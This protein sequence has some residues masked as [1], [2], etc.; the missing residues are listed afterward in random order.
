MNRENHHIRNFYL[1]DDD[2]DDCS[3]FLEAL[4]EVDQQAQLTISH[5]GARLMETLARKEPPTPEIIFLDLNMPLKNGFECLREI[6]QTPGLC[7]IPVIIYSTS[8]NPDIVEQT[9]Q[10]GANFYICKPNS[11]SILKKTIATV[12]SYD[13]K[14]LREQPLRDLFV[15]SI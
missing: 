2:D 8:S 3:L 11:F 9:Y 4:Q 7:N 13:F 14:K 5:N 6:R 15:I 10:H 12:L 1:T